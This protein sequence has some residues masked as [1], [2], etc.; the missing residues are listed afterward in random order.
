M[1]DRRTIHSTAGRILVGFP[2][3]AALLFL[4]ACG[5]D[6]GRKADLA[7][8]DIYPEMEAHFEEHSD[9]FKFKTPED[10]PADLT[11]EDGMD[12]PEL[13]SPDA[14]RGGTANGRIQDFP[15]TL[16]VIGPDSNSSFRPMLL[17]DVMMQ[18]AHF[19]PNVEGG[20][21]FFPGLAKEWAVDMES[22]TVFVR[23]NPEA[24]WSDGPE[25]TTDDVMFSFFFWQSPYIRAPWYN[26][27]YSKGEVY[28][29]VTRYDKYT[30]SI[31][32]EER[33]PDLAFR[34]LNLSPLPMHFYRE[35]GEDF[36]ERYQWRF[37]PTSGAYIITDE[38]LRR[39]R[40][41]R[42]GITL[43]FDE[44]WWAK[45]N[46]YWRYRFN[47]GKLRFKVIRDTSKAF[48]TFLKGELDAFG[49]NL[50]EYHYEK[51]PNDHPLVENGYIKK[52]TFYNDVPRPTYGLWINTS[53]PMLDNKDVRWGIQ[54][55]TNWQ[56][57]IDQYFRGDYERMRTTADGYGKMTHPDIP[58]RE[59]DPEKARAYFAK[60][61]FTEAGPDGVLQNEA[62]QRLSF[63]LTSGYESLAPVL[64]ILKQEA[65]K[66]GL[67][68]QVEVLDGSA[69]W[70]KV[71]E[72]NHDIQ[73]SA[74]NVSV[75][76]Y[77][78]YWETY[79]SVN[80]YDEPFLE[81][82]VTPNPDRKPKTQTN[83]LE[84]IALPELD[85]R[86]EA[87]RSSDDLEEMRELAYEME[88]ILY[89]Y[90]SFVP[91]FVMPFYRIAYWR[92]RDYPEDFNVRYSRDA[93][94]YFLSWIVPGAKEKTLEA[95]KA[96]ETFPK[97]VETFDR[98]K[99]EY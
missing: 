51:L 91:G 65:L 93:G 40:T 54:H 11:W 74:F 39:I 85:K 97:A 62:G 21:Q 61:G 78:R 64:A 23:L 9:F 77:P 50:A 79:H 34:V 1:T 29:Q 92:W 83:N 12:L 27:Y 42:D 81:D 10:I 15:R 16:R 53:R 43:T 48:E 60:A 95:M 36:V 57:V 2:L 59:F 13:G 25:I 28:S 18:F 84:L 35:L 75:E 14:V 17:D 86:I 49:M 44:D 82:G 4:A 7:E 26:N 73:F 69:A 41:N 52:A 87:Y 33:R 76:M 90:A 20:F 30:F 99:V 19:H 46:K 37:M 6:V 68:F 71:Q 94:E 63:T 67:E 24:R 72:K 3:T 70:K 80:A 31:T 8:Q 22:K 55:A 5:G 45:D 56:L 89:D 88:E 47:P 38:E 32:L 98:W 58:I 66:A 96:G